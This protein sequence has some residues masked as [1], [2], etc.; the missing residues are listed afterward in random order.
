[1]QPQKTRQHGAA[2]Y[3]DIDRRVSAAERKVRLAER[4]R[5]QARDT[6]TESQRWLGDPPPDRSALARRNVLSKEPA[7]YR[8]GFHGIV[9]QLI[10]HLRRQ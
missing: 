9:D 5:Q 4:D 2:P 3:V 7:T 1:M 6:R 10:S 8:A